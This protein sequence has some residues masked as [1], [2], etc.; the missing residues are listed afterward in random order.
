M[1]REGAYRA[2][3]VA[4]VGLVA[5]APFV[6]MLFLALLEPASL[7]WLSSGAFAGQ[8][9][10][11]AAAVVPFS[12]LAG[13]VRG[14][15]LLTPFATV[16]LGSN[17]LPRRATLRR[18][19][20]RSLLTASAG[21]A[22]LAAL[23]GSALV[24]GAGAS[25]IGALSFVTAASAL[26][27]LGTVGALVGQL[28]GSARAWGAAVL[29]VAFALSPIGI[30]AWMSSAWAGLTVGAPAGGAAL[31]GLAAESAAGVLCLTGAAGLAL[32]C[33]PALLDRLRGDVLLLQ[34][35]HR[36]AAQ[37]AVATGEL[38]E[39]TTP[40]REAPT[41]GR[42][43]S[44]VVGGPRAA[45]MLVRDAVGALRTPQRTVLG[46]AGLAGA[47][48]L[49]G[50]VVGPGGLGAFAAVT[51]ALGSVV[52]YSSLGAFAEGF[53]HAAEAAAGPPIFGAPVGEEFLLHAAFPVA[54]VLAVIGTTML[55]S[56]GSFAPLLGGLSVV[57]VRAFEA[58]RGPLP[59]LLLT[60]MPSEIGDLS[61]VA[62]LFWQFDSVLIAAALGA[63]TTLLW[64][65]GLPVLSFAAFVAGALSLALAT[66][67]RLRQSRG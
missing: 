62:R 7:A 57:A 46:V 26:A 60:P 25:P 14:P 53:R 33:V 23:V 43:L 24:V 47:A 58:A 55:I 18:P 28:I 27:C 9:Q 3:L 49:L 54:V 4:A 35:R 20:V 32:A 13:A 51:A 52:I 5:V 44:A 1:R 38:S 63:G 36:E 48:L 56:G 42:R 65:A 29:V 16:T 31:A 6:R 15:A 11:I 59:P 8:L 37:M 50:L 64:T 22:G 19:F 30:G 12:L 2:Y 66:R 61:A 40:Y 10:V 17:H 39:A 45:A 67:F 41:V 34:A 21:A